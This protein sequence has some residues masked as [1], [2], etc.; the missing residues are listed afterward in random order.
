MK[1]K[2][3]T[4]SQRYASALRKH[5]K[6]GPES[7]LQP[8]RGLGRQAVSL[9]LETLDLARIHERT[10]ALLEA[11]SSRDG[12]IKRAESFFTEAITPIEKTHR[13]ALKAGARLNRAN[14][15][16]GRRTEDL[17]ASNPSLKQGV[18]RRKTVEAALKKSKEHYKTLLA[19]S[20]ALQKHLQRLT[21]RILSAQEDKRKQ[22]SH[23]LQDEI[24]QTMLGINVR[25][26]TVKKA[27]GRSAISLQKEIA[28]TQGLV[29]MSVKTIER[30]AREYGKH[31]EP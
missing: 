14:Q 20:L 15:A 8:A 3:S 1:R 13:A 5:L 24:A 19:E 17:A 4:L 11:S 25:L 6:Q 16:L 18:A 21:H 10:L 23:E 28:N 2:L 22:L 26:L 30:L 27:A 29:N 12:L 7:S 9:G 31:Y